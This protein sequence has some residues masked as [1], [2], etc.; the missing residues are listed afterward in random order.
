VNSPVV[1]ISPKTWDFVR[2]L[3][4]FSSHKLKQPDN[5][6][7]LLELAQTKNLKGELEEIAFLAKFLSNSYVILKRGGNDAVDYGKLSQEF[8]SNLDKVIEELKGI[9]AEAPSTTNENFSSRFFSM[10]ADGFENLMNLLYDLSW[11]K[12][13]IIDQKP[14]A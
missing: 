1:E 2:Q 10:T 5:I 4:D 12:N 3:G 13:W 7:V 6:A 11:L 8:R 14:F 9:V